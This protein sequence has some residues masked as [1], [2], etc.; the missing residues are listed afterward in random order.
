[1]PAYEQI[2]FT[3]FQLPLRTPIVMTRIAPLVCHVD[4]HA[5]THPLEVARQLSTNFGAVDVAENATH[6]FESLQAVK[7]FHWT[8][9]TGVPHFIAFLKVAEY[10]LIEEP[11]SVGNDANLHEYIVRD[12][13][14]KRSLATFVHGA[15][16]A[17]HQAH[18]FIPLMA[19]VFVNLIVVIPG[20]RNGHFPGLSVNARVI[21]GNFVADRRS[22]DA[23]EV[24]DHLQ[25]FT[26]RNSLNTPACRAGRYPALAIV[27]GSIDHQRVAL[28][29]ANRVAIPL[30]DSLGK[31]LGRDQR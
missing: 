15:A 19:R 1:M 28:P 6:R 17:K 11:M 10:G 27:V 13:P 7:H 31:M 21:D 24:L 16:A 12:Q 23:G 2:R 26:L 9:V 8:E 20:H 4:A 5:F 25:R 3:L 22:V 18:G 29:V 30:T 14:G